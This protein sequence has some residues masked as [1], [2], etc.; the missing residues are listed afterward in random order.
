MKHPEFVG[1]FFEC[2]VAEEL[3]IPRSGEA[4]AILHLVE[5]VRVSKD[6]IHS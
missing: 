1:V 5:A 3:P 4:D 2:Y 6:F